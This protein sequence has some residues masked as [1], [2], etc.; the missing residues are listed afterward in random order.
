MPVRSYSRNK[1]KAYDASRDRILATPSE[2]ALIA[3]LE[4]GKLGEYV[5]D[6]PPAAHHKSWFPY[7]RTGKDS[8][9]LRQYAG[10]NTDLLAPRG[11]AKSTWIAIATADIIGHNPHA[12]IL[13]L[14]NS[15]DLALRQSRLIKRIIET[16]RF[17]EVFPHIKP[18]KRW[19]D[20]DWEIDKKYAG[21]SQLD[22]D[23]TLKAYGI[24][25]SVIGGRFHVIIGDDLIKSSKA[26]ANPRVR[27]DMQQTFSEVI[28]PCLVPGGRM[29]DIGTRF[30]R[31]DI[32]VTEFNPD[33]GWITVETQAIITKEDR[34]EESY[35]G[36][37]YKL[38]RLQSLRKRK[39]TI[40]TYQ[41]QNQ[42]PPDDEDVIIKPEWIKYGTPPERFNK[43]VLGMDLAASEKESGDQTAFVLVGM[44]RKPFKLWVLGAWAGRWVG[45]VEKLAQ[46]RKI[47]ETWGA[48]ELAVES[49][50]YQRSLIGDFRTVFVNQWGIRN[51]IAHPVPSRGDKHERLNG[52]SGV[53]A[54]G[55]VEFDKSRDF[56]QLVSQLTFQSEA[57]EDDLSD[58]CEKAIARL[59]GSNRE[60]WGA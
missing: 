14:S 43:L 44:I 51:V 38:E 15:R 48:F 21:V 17:Q 19:A 45:N 26:I 10:D 13:Y 16:P 60:I 24:L 46:V 28:E 20:T 39:P 11:S 32:H 36:D 50:A 7:L 27:E 52:V 6:K 58:A 35:W 22:S 31:D 8:E 34:T 9:C 53:F 40:F 1:W 55:F 23:A 59:Q 4:L 25:G 18:G 49:N 56:H 37:R 54:N 42:L 2:E 47:R 29:L 5:A 41:F 57:D 33:N 3:R 30:R 12:Q